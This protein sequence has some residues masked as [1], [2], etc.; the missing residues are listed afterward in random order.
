MRLLLQI[1]AFILAVI[2]FFIKNQ[3]LSCIMYFL[4]FIVAIYNIIYIYNETVEMFTIA[5]DSIFIRKKSGHEIIVKIDNILQCIVRSQLQQIYINL[6]LKNTENNKKR[7]GLHFWHNLN[8]I[9]LSINKLSEKCD[10]YTQGWW[11]L[12]KERKKWKLYE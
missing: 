12:N 10:V 9:K 6:D 4:F 7:I 11:F 5:D 3:L 2:G 8:K 1:I